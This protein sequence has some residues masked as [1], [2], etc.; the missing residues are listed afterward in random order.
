M[1]AEVTILKLLNVKSVPVLPLHPDVPKITLVGVL[2]SRANFS[3]SVSSPL[4]FAT[5]DSIAFQHKAAFSNS[6]GHFS[7]H[8]FQ[9]QSKKSLFFNS[10]CLSL[11][12]SPRLLT[13]VTNLSRESTLRQAQGDRACHGE[14]A[15]SADR[16]IEPCIPAQSR[17]IGTGMTHYSC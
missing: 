5:S 1:I 8:R 10:F 2:L 4:F 6:W 17:F 16:L 11:R 13:S 15:C 12:Q 7:L 14:P 9:K 3:I